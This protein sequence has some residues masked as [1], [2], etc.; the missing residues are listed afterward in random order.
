M[1]SCGWI[2][3]KVP[4]FSFPRQPHSHRRPS[5]FVYIKKLPLLP[6]SVMKIQRS[7]LPDFRAVDRLCRAHRA[8]FIAIEPRIIRGLSVSEVAAIFQQ[9][10]YRQASIPMLPTR[11]L[12]IDLRQSPKDLF[13]TFKK[14]ARTSI[15]KTLHSCRFRVLDPQDEA[16]RAQFYSFWKTYGRGFV[17]SVSNFQK[18]LA[19]FGSDSFF[20]CTYTGKGQLLAASLIL[21]HNK[22]ASYYFACVSPLGR[23]RLAG[24]LVVWEAIL[25][26]KRRG[27][28]A[29]DLEG[30]YD[31][32]FPGLRRWKG[33]SQFKQKFGGK[34]IVYPGSFTRF[35][36]PLFS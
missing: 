35:S 2:V 13:R 21:V 14:D 1:A 6:F 12:Q 23:P 19:A 24:Y 17:F 9:H 25:E 16:Q 28:T 4:P 33:F 8:V 31:Q 11:T 7:S 15:R 27:C 34:E 3:G 26:A 30:V 18:L 10:G 20:V 5:T 32:R 29:F 36:L 22:S